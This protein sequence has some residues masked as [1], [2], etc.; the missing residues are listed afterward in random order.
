MNL[1]DRRV[2]KTRHQIKE[3]LVACLNNKP[4]EKI[5]ITE[6]CTRA[7]I[8]R[9]TFYDHYQSVAEVYES[10]EEEAA[11]SVLSY[12]QL[13]QK[14]NTKLEDSIKEILQFIDQRTEV[15]LFIIKHSFAKMKEVNR[16]AFIQ[17]FANIPNIPK[18]FRENYYYD[19]I[20][21][22]TQNI[23]YTWVKEG[24]KESVEKMIEIIMGIFNIVLYPIS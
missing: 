19:F 14:S 16:L 6:L 18:I 4:I 9:S 22:G 21:S 5:N 8:N 2:K 12:Y 11:K 15:Y 20:L 23:V 17:R 10:L 1:D 7:K 3:A 24:K 13:L